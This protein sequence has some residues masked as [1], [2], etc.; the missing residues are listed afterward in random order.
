MTKNTINME[1]EDYE[2]EARPLFG[3]DSKDDQAA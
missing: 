2:F 3:A 1:G